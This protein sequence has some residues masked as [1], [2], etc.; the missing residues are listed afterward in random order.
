MDHKLLLV[1]SITLLYRESQLPNPIDNSA[2][3][4]HKILELIKVPEGIGTFGMQNDPIVNL[5]QTAL[6]MAKNPVNYEY[7]K[8]EL[9]QRIRVNVGNDD[10]MFSAFY[11]G[12]NDD[13]SETNVR[14]LCKQLR[15]NL[16]VFVKKTKVKEKIKTASTK[17]LFQEESIDWRYFIQELIDEL[18]PFKNLEE[19]RIDKNVVTDIMLS[20]LV[21]VEEVFDRSLKEIT[22]DGVIR[23]GLQGL[24][25]M[26]GFAGGARR[27]EFI[28]VGALQHNYKSGLALDMFKGAAL[29]NKPYLRDPQRKPM[30]MRLSFENSMETD[31]NH[32][33]K[34]MVEQETGLEVVPGTF[35]TREAAGYIK[36]KLE[37]N[38]WHINMAHY[39]PTQMTYHDIQEK[40][41]RAEADGFEVAM[42]N[43]DYLNMISKRGCEQ[44]PMGADIRDLYRKM[45]N[46]GYRRGMTIVTPHQLS[47]EAKMLTRE[48]VQDFVKEIAN[49]GYY[50]GCRTID[51][52]VDMEIYIHIVIVNG[53]SY[54]TFQ[55]GKHRKPGETPLK[56]RYFVQKFEKI[57]GLKD[58]VLGSDT[59]RK[60]VGGN[61]MA[62]GGGAAWYTGV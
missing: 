17:V 36:D 47:T 11:D 7:D 45:R 58:D 12:V 1:K 56:D 2:E 4:V 46:F 53:E 61:T 35:T 29:Y 43:L 9:L 50:D 8:T 14:K 44:G 6:W 49:K 52:E 15:E 57:G 54:L 3:L 28:V 48:G 22:S 18:T 5:R 41:L 23:F 26:F 34:Y 16:H 21:A 40:V 10:S 32:L 27:G 51:Q 31:L 38:G 59:S 20:D 33:Y 62:E 37:A 30:L 25:R 39:D 19:S 55:R 24:N 13:L 60:T 42:L